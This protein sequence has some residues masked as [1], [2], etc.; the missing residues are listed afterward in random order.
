MLIFLE[1]LPVL[2]GLVC[3]VLAF[4]PVRRGRIPHPCYTEGIIAGRRSQRMYRHHN[5][6]ELFAPVVRYSTP[7]GE[8]TAVSRTYLPEW[9]Y[10]FRTGDTVK[11]C[12]HAQQPDVFIICSDS[13]GWRRGVL[14]TIGLGTILA[15]GVLWLQYF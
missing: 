4:V 6:A 7:Q 8:I 3:I 14:L 10:G 13:S 2:I 9:Q 11:I 15:Y 5:E 12:Y 1:G